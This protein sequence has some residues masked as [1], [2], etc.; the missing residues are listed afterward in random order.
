M[1][2]VPSR[3]PPYPPPLLSEEAGELGCTPGRELAWWR[4]SA[5][6]DACASGPSAGE[7]CPTGSRQVGM[8]HPRP[9][10][11]PAHRPVNLCLNFWC[12]AAFL[13]IKKNKSQRSGLVFG[14]WVAEIVRLYSTH[15]LLIILLPR[16]EM[17]F[18]FLL[19]C[20]AGHRC[21][22]SCGCGDAWCW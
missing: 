7:T 19:W 17:R 15:F 8:Y 21:W 20:R 13:H 4:V 5:G 1:P 9:Q 11:T 16:A 18:R 12:N 3:P 22:W 6:G 2:S 10:W 14:F